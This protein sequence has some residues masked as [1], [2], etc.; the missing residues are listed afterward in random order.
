L[1]GFRLGDRSADGSRPSGQENKKG[2]YT[3]KDNYDKTQETE[4]APIHSGGQR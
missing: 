4:N 3:S 2:C 1:L